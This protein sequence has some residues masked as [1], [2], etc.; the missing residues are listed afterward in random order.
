[1]SAG[2]APEV[3]ALPVMNWP[4]SSEQL[5]AMVRATW[6][7]VFMGSLYALLVALPFVGL[8]PDRVLV[9]WTALFV[10]VRVARL[11]AARRWQATPPAGRD[12]RMWSWSMALNAAAQAALWGFGSWWLMAP[13]QPAAEAALHLGLSIVTLTNVQTLARTYPLLFFYTLLVMGPLALRD[14]WLGG[15][16]TM[17]GGMAVLV[18]TYAL[19]SGLQHAR[20]HNE[21]LRQRQRNA[22]LIAA[23]QQEVEARTAAQARA[24]QAHAEKAHFLAAAGHDLRQPLNAIGLLAQALPQEQAG[25]PLALAAQRIYGC[26]EQMGDIVDGL[27]ELSHLDAGTVQPQ[28]A[29]LDLA[30]LLQSLA[31]Q[32]DEA[33]RRKGL[34]LELQ[35][36]TDASGLHTVSDARLLRRVLD[37]LVS[38]A[39][40]YTEAGSVV[41]RAVATQ[42]AVRV[43]V[44]DTGVGIAAAELERVFEPFYQTGN[45][46]R[47]QRHGHGLGL[48]IVQ[49]LGRLLGLG[50]RVSSV[51]GQGSCFTLHLP[52]ARPASPQVASAPAPAPDAADVLHGRRVLVVEDDP[53]SAEALTLLLGRWG[54]QVRQAQCM[55]TALAAL[56]PEWQPEFVVADLRLAE[57]DDGCLTALQLRAAVGGHL[58]A[59]LVTGE[60]GHARA[61]AARAEGFTVLGKPL[62]PAQLRACMN[63]AFARRP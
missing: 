6:L 51:P 18:G 31:A 26:V 11:V 57:G 9:V 33:A 60:L 45:P 62:R 53:A 37:N 48:A 25:P 4:L 35:L 50:L 32:H 2:T 17:L 24:E 41:L 36:H 15:L 58:P 19:V 12:L 42:E 47:D 39:V 22:E 59:V 16:H 20:A 7:T 46:G 52:A 49:R 1:M 10:A 5:D 63:D 14:L 27:M 38:N 21:T 54:C 13:Q 55:T 3:R 56:R 8:V 28:L 30:G 23:L 40:R 44:V 61:E 34:R 43:E 29:P